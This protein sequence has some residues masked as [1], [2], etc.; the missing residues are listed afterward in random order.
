[1]MPPAA[2]AL[3][4][5]E[6]NAFLFARTGEDRNGMPVSVLS[7]LA[8]LDMDPWQEEAAQLPASG[9][10]KEA[11]ARKCLLSFRPWAW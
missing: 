9:R 3:P 11:Y 7:G 6:F 10:G 8:R 1:M 5:A 4:R 2:I